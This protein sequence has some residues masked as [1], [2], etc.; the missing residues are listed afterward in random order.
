MTR[1][2]HPHEKMGQRKAER[3]DINKQEDQRP[4]RLRK[5]DNPEKTSDNCRQ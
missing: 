5:G 3:A 4:E 1:N 2:D